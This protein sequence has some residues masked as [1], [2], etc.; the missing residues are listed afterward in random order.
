MKEQTR[1][2]LFD[3]AHHAE[4]PEDYGITSKDVRVEFGLSICS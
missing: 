3:V 2:E 1:V 4:C